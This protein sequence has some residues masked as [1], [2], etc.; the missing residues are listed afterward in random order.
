MLRSLSST[1]ESLSGAFAGELSTKTAE[2]DSKKAQAQSLARELA[3]KRASLAHWRREAARV[4]QLE[5]SI[6]NLARA[7]EEEDA[8]DWTGRTELDGSPASQLA[9]PSFKYRGPAS[10]LS[11]LPPGISIEFDADP[12]VPETTGDQVSGEALVH[13]LRLQAWYER[14]EG[15]MQQRL[16]KL[17]GGNAEKER[18][19]RKIVAGCCGVEEENV[20]DMLEGL[21]RSLESCV[22]SFPPFS[23]S[24]LTAQ[25]LCPSRPTVTL[26]QWTSRVSPAFS[27]ASRKAH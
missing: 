25:Y 26:L 10:T 5:Q 9:G 27:A 17:E 20:D 12:A 1:L 22:H 13:L 11:N 3:E 15:L 4:D 19:L 18:K 16:E 24:S 8:F 7:V 21:V 6:D 2:L 23:A 14:V